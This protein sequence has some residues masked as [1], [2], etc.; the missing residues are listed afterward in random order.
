MDSVSVA[1]FT[2]PPSPEAF[3]REVLGELALA[4]GLDFTALRAEWEKAARLRGTELRVLGEEG[5]YRGVRLLETGELEVEGERGPRRLSSEEV[6][7]R[8]SG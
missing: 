4:L 1:R 5:T 7:V 8:F 6:S 2:A 3:A